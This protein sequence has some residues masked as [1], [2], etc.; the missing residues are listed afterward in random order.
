MPN[1]SVA[2][3]RAID[4]ILTMFENGK[5]V[6]PDAYGT[7]TLISGDSGGLSYGKHQ[8]T[9]NS[10]SLGLLVQAYCADPAADPNLK[11][12][13]AVFL[14]RLMDRDPSLDTNA[15]LRDLLRRAGDDP[16]MGPLQDKFF[17]Q[18]YMTPSMKTADAIGVTTALGAAVVY[19]SFI[20]GAWKIVH[21]LNKQKV[22]SVQTVGEHAWIKSYV[23]TRRHW[24]ANH[25]NPVLHNTVY[26]MDCFLR[27]IAENKWDLSLPVNLL[28]PGRRV[29][30]VTAKM[31]GLGDT[32]PPPAVP[33]LRPAGAASAE[34]GG[35]RR[36]LRLR[37]P[38]LTGDDVMQIQVVLNTLGYPVT[39]SGTYDGLTAEAVRMFQQNAGHNLKVDGMVGPATRAALGIND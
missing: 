38:V 24:L 17:A 18:V 4:A 21:P 11:A 25:S 6:G 19:D 34:T 29:W 30:V 36:L 3:I 31:L 8:V 9:R 27:L 22:G 5:P 1:L 7:V 26:R 16:Y 10:G 12:G 2:Q 39:A 15:A 35:E 28:G 20:H 37:N 23:E 14:D 32:E 33:A 13:L